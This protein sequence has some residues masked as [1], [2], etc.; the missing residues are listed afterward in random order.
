MYFIQHC[1][2]CRPLDSTVSGDGGIESRTVA[3]L[4]LAVRRSYTRLDLIYH[5]DVCIVPVIVDF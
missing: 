1:F 5:S 4:T 2:I 3:N